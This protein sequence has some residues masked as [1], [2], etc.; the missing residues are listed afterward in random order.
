MPPQSKPIKR[1]PRR[2]PKSVKNRRKSLA[3]RTARGRCFSGHAEHVLT[4]RLAK[5]LKGKVDLILTS[6]PFP[7]NTKKKYK[8]LQGREYVRWLKKFAPLFKKLLRPK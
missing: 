2:P 5:T 4:G 6:P 8:N 3:Y 1:S 7:L